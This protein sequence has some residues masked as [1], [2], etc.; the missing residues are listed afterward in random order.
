MLGY[1]PIL[2]RALTHPLGGANP[3]YE[4]NRDRTYPRGWKVCFAPRVAGLRRDVDAHPSF[5]WPATGAWKD[6]PDG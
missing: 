1:A 2:R 6:G 5:T 3:T 4:I